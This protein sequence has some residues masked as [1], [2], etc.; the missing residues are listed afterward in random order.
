[1]LRTAAVRATGDC[2]TLNP[3]AFPVYGGYG[4][5]KRK[6]CGT[7]TRCLAGRA[8]NQGRSRSARRVDLF[9]GSHLVHPRELGRALRKV[10]RW[11]S[12]RRLC[13]VRFHCRLQ[14]ASGGC[15]LARWRHHRA[16]ST[17]IGFAVRLSGVAEPAGAITCSSRCRFGDDAVISV[18]SQTEGN[19]RQMAGHERRRWALQFHYS[20][21][22]QPS[23]VRCT[24]VFSKLGIKACCSSNCKG[25]ADDGWRFTSRSWPRI[26]SNGE[27]KAPERTCLPPV[28]APRNER[29]DPGSA[30]AGRCRM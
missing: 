8:K 28:A 25:M 12:P 20:A 22:R 13:L 16:S 18:V 15:E 26:L 4:C 1:M 30:P 27:T 21:I 10:I 2:A 7:Q 9:K 6:R 5:R 23:T 17:A 24:L 19:R 14:H 11:Q 3:T 29:P